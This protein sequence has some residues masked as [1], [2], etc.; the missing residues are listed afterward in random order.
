M[1]TPANFQSA[2]AAG[3]CDFLALKRALG[4]RYRTEEA[5]L[6]LLDR[7]LVQQKV[8][9]PDEL[10][11][12]LLDAFLTSRPRSAP[13][14]FNHLLGV[15]RQCLRWLATQGRLPA[16]LLQTRPRH[17]TS[18][19]VPFLFTPEQAR[20]LLAAAAALPDRPRGPGR[21][22]TYR[23]IFALLYGL[24]LRVGEACRL[25][26]GDVDLPQALLVIRGTKFGKSRLVPV[27]PRVAA[28]LGSHLARR[29]G[30][31]P[32]LD[33]AAPLFT[34][35]GRHGVTAGTVSQT[36]L[37]LTRA[38]RL[39][40]AAGTAPPRCHDLRHSFAVATLLRWYRTGVDPAGRLHHLATFLG[41][42]DPASTAVYLTITPDLFAEAADRFATFAG[43]ALM[44]V[45]R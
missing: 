23:T 3:F 40:G 1:S 34:F 35:D 38:L 11:A 13:R 41:H 28:L 15:V 12:E 39:A 27:G 5:A 26:V 37:R 25:Q 33:P 22:P 16:S 24:G 4:R 29:A 31:G 18:Q 21:G 14:S 9:G 10:T 19:R 44:E 43:P 45:P 20:A 6:R 7:F 36:F 42:V 8:T 30:G 17:V 2:L 32:P